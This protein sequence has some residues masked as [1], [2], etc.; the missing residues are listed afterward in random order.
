MWYKFT[1]VSRCLLLGAAV[2]IDHG[3]AVDRVQITGGAFLEAHGQIPGCAAAG[4]EGG[5]HHAGAADNR[6][7]SGGQYRAVGAPA[8]THSKEN[9]QFRITA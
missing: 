2:E 5:G 4:A 6:Q 7:L 1:H 8:D 3:A 9:S